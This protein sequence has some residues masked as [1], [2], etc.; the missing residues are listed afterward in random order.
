MCQTEAVRTVGLC[1]LFTVDFLVYLCMHVV[2]SSASD[3]WEHSANRSVCLCGSGH[4]RTQHRFVPL[5]MHCQYA[6]VIEPIG[7]RIAM[8]CFWVTVIKGAKSWIHVFFNS[9]CNECVT[10]WHWHDRSVCI[11]PTKRLT[12]H[13]L[14]SV[15]CHHCASSDIILC[16]PFVWGVPYVW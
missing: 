16:L 4:S 3:V 15:R 2:C 11:L 13:M 10:V 9:P 6:S 7:V 8:I 12:T 14:R 1:V 5:S